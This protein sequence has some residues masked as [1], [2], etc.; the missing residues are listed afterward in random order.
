MCTHA[1][2]CFRLLRGR[3][4]RRHSLAAGQRGDGVTLLVTLGGR[5]SQTTTSVQHTKVVSLVVVFSVGVLFGWRRHARG[6]VDSGQLCHAPSGG[7]TSWHTNLHI[8][9]AL[10]RRCR[11][12]G[13]VA[14]P[15][16]RLKTL[17]CRSGVW[18]GNGV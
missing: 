16:L 1:R 6:A 18:R 3:D 2:S 4:L 11:L 12:R 13:G 5:V 15:A 17:H 7:N 10:Q 9:C 8:F 14:A